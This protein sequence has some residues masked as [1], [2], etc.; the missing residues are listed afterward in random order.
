M[1]APDSLSGH[2]AIPAP[3][4][5]RPTAE[6]GRETLTRPT[7]QVALLQLVRALARQA[8]REALARPDPPTPNSLK[9]FP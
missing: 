6:V 9:E 5:A 7:G 8:T 2:G 4:Q 1:A 3:Q